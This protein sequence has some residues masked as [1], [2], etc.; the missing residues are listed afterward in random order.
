[1]AD[2]F[3]S[4]V[5]EDRGIAEKISRGL[6]GAGLSVWWDRHI[7]GGVDFTK[8]IDRQLDTARVVI[9]LWS[10][11]SVDSDW[12]RD[13]AQQAREQKKLIPIRLDNVQ[14]PLGFR[15]LQSLDLDGW[16]GDPNASGFASL[17]DSARRLLGRPSTG[18]PAAITLPVTPKYGRWGVPKTRWL[19]A[20]A[21]MV[22][23]AVVVALRFGLGSTAPP[24]DAASGRIEIGR[25]E[26]LAQ[27][28][29]TAHF[30]KGLTDAIRRVFAAN[31]IK[32]VAPKEGAGTNVSDVSAEFGLRGTVDRD[33]GQYVVAADILHRRDGLVL[34]SK[35]LHQDFET[36]PQFQEHV[37]MY[38]TSVLNCALRYRALAKGDLAVDLF[39]RFIEF[40]EALQSQ[41]FDQAT[42]LAQRIVDAAP[43]YGISHALLAA[44]DAFRSTLA[45]QGAF[46][47]APERTRLRT[48]AYSAAKVAMELD[49][50]HVAGLID[51]TF[52]IVDDPSRDLAERE[53]LLQKNLSTDPAFEGQVLW[54]YATLLERVG[55]TDEARSYYLQREEAFPADRPQFRSIELIAALG[56]I[57]T[58]RAEFA[59]LEPTR[60]IDEARFLVEFLYGDPAVAKKMS[61]DERYARFL[62]PSKRACMTA[63]L[64]AKLQRTQLSVEEIDA[65]CAPNFALPELGVDRE[66]AELYAA[67]GHVDEAYRLLEANRD[68]YA[69]FIVQP[70]L[71]LPEMRSVRADPRFMPFAARVGLVDYWLETDH[72]PDFC[73]HDTLPYDCK[74]AALAARAA[75]VK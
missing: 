6:E 52:A 59:S 4:Y 33:D 15:Q 46:I 44:S 27:G 18:A 7:P 54:A 8:E 21:I 60:P 68:F 64:D 22:V 38:V 30:A 20:A 17:V 73:T 13:E 12:V 62:Q 29:D 23:I 34:W 32:T 25:F 2:V 5:S 10:R 55:R 63:I 31:D 39:S 57:D 53:Q 47:P 19:A 50:K 16:K 61:G 70:N 66:M 45:P 36:V 48:Q 3:V 14:P 72:W 35:T 67:F 74:E 9:V 43:Q 75:A 51:W 26:S 65:A 49:P 11:T 69:T 56:D 71:F 37:S 28:D 24:S 40:C 58:A 1:V 42:G 41:Q